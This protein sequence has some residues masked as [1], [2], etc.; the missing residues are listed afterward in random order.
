MRV[1]VAGL[2][3]QGYK[4]RAVAGPDFVGSVDPVNA[5]ADYR[6]LEDVPTERYDAVLACIPDDPKIALLNYCVD[7]R[8]HV[9]VEKPLWAKS[10]EQISALEA[11]ARKANVVCY[12]AYNHR[13]EPHYVRMRDLI[14]GNQL[15]K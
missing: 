3:V 4:R 9:L 15:G 2:G 12:T 14:A 6:R 13:F 8:K 5:E 1:V 7:K 10:A 11:R